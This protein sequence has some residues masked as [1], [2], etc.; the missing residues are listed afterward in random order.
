MSG[1][2]DFTDIIQTFPAARPFADK[3]VFQQFHLDDWPTLV[4]PCV[5]TS[6]QKVSMNALP[7]NVCLGFMR[8]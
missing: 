6:R 3:E 5:S 4:W 1:I 2:V 7:A 8:A